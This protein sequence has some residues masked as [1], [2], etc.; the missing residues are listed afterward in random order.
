VNAVMN[1]QVKQYVRNLLTMLVTISFS[2]NTPHR[3]VSFFGQFVK[4]SFFYQE[5]TA[6]VAKTFLSSSKLDKAIHSFS[7]KK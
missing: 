6:A 3:G 7:F 1:L 4:F 5:I 2:R